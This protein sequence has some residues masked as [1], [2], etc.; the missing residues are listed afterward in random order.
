MITS[1]GRRRA[2]GSSHLLLGLIAVVGLVWQLILVVQQTDVLAEAAGPLP[3]TGTRVIRFFSYFT[4]QSNLLVAVVELWLA[5]NPLQDGRV[6]RVLRLEALVGITVTGV[7][8]ATL[9]RGV[10]NL[11]GAAAITNS[12]VH[13]IVPAMAVLVWLAFGPRP[14]ITDNTLVLSLIWPLLYVTYS[15]AH[16]AA[17]DWY[18]YPFVDVV[19]LGYVT[20]IRNSIGL[21]LL[22]VGVGALYMW[23]DHHLPG[24]RSATAPEPAVSRS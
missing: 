16:G 2:A 13:Y 14:R 19:K 22:L 24:D 5:K 6:F 3:G 8:Y 9:L 7:V 10:V 15:F 18:P 1:P 20:T 23:L 12:I 11:H 4:V 17:S 21:N